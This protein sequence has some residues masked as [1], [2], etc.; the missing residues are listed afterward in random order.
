MTGFLNLLK[1]PGMSSHDMISAARRA[2]GVKRIGHAGTLDPAAA[3]VLPVAVG[4][5]AR[6]LE[7][8]ELA[9]KSYRAEVLFGVATDSGD[10]T[11]NILARGEDSVPEKATLRETLASLTGEQEQTPPAHSAV[12]INGRRAYDLVRSGEKVNIPSRRVHIKD[13]RLVCKREHSIVIDVDCSKGTYIR[14]LII[15][16]G[17]RLGLLTTMG[18]LLRTRVGDFSIEE[19]MTLEELAARGEASLLPPET[20]LSHMNRYNIMASRRKAFCNGLAT[21]VRD[22]SEEGTYCVFSDGAFLGIGR[23]SGKSGELT[24]VKVIQQEAGA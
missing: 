17:E 2:L 24:P 3:G 15:T 10:D 12:K 18:F 20:M 19:A 13:I 6:L 8:L 5:A 16:L 22:I 1:P 14:S 9:D 4:Q 7:Y 23:Y 21:G 11:G